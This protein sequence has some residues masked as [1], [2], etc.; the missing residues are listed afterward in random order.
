M[1]FLQ[2]PTNL[3]GYRARPDGDDPDRCI[4]EAYALERYPEGTEIPKIEIEYADNW[5]DIDWGLILAQD[6]QNMEEVQRGMKVRGF[7]AVRPNPIQEFA[8]IN[9]HAMLNRFIEKKS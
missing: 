5:R 7:K 3:L 2:S 8:V 9:F 6:F 4:F 1:V